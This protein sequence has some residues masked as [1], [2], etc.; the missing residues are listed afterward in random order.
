VRRLPPNDGRLTSFGTEVPRG[1]QAALLRFSIRF[2]GIIAALACIL[3]GFGL[4]DLQEAKFDVFPE[5]APPQTSIQ[6]EAPGLAPEQVEV[7][8]TQV[9]ENNLNGI[10]GVRALLS[11]S[12]PGLSVINVTFDPSSDIHLDRQIVAERLGAAASQLPSGVPAPV[13]EPLTSSTS[14]VLIVG[15]TSQ[16][17]S[18]M[19]LRTAAQWTIVP[20]L[21]AVPGVSKVAV[22]GGETKSIQIQVHPDQLKRFDLSLADVAAA[23]RRATGI[24]GAGVIDSPNQRI[25]LQASG[26]AVTAAEIA[27]TVLA[28]GAATNI[29]L[30]NVAD[31]IEAPEPPIG[32]AEIDGEPSVVLN[33]S[34]QYGANTL[35]V[36]RRLDAAFADLRPGLARDGIDLRDDLFRP[37]NFI[38]LA[39]GNVRNSLFLGGVLVVIV[40]FLFLFDL[41]TAAISSIAIPL[42]LLPAVT[43]LHRLDITLNTMTLGGLA[44]AIGVVVDDAVVDI[45]NIA[46]RLR[47]NSNLKS[48][49]PMASVVFDACFEVRNAVVYA[50][51]AVLLV[52]LP[53][54]FLP[55]IAGRLFAPLAV[56]YG[57]ATLA[58]LIVALTVTPAFAMLMLRARSNPH[59]P[60]L[61]QWARRH[62]EALLGNIA[63]RPRLALFAAVLAVVAGCAALPTF[64]ATFIPELK[65]GHYTVH[66]TALPGTSIAESLRL[67]T[68]VAKSL[69]EIPAIRSVTQRA[70][71][72]ELADETNGTHHSEIE[73]DLKPT[74]AEEAEKTLVEI[75]ERLAEIPGA[76]F[77]VNTFLT[78]RIEETLSGFTAPVVVN[79]LGNDL[80]VL[81]QKARQIARI[82]AKVRGAADV[83]VQSPPGMPV[84]NIR[85]RQDDLARWGLTSIEVLDA[86]SV[87]Y[88]G[89]K[90]G[91]IYDGSQ[92]FPVLV[93]LDEASRSDV[94][95]VGDL[96]LL[97]KNGV[98]LNLS[99]VA[100]IYP[101]SGRYTIAHENARR[102]QTVTANV[103]GRDVAS[104]VEEAKAQI[105]SEVSFPGGTYVEYRGT[106]EAQ[107]RS[108]NALILN[109]LV[110]GIGIALV[111]AMITRNARNLLLVLANIPFALVGG[112][113]AVFL[114][115]GTLSLGSM[116]G[117]VALF[118]ITLRNSI[119]MI[120]HYRDLVDVE[121]LPWK[122][123]TAVRGASD[124][125]APIMMTSLVTALGVLPL[126]LGMGEP[127]R[128]IEGPMAVVILGGLMTSMVLNLLLLPTLALRYGDF[129]PTAERDEFREP[130]MQLKTPPF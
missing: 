74:N 26:Q 9:L 112:V 31:V 96:P 84:L 29:T 103:T 18:L 17:R 27:R 6:T 66:M 46:R 52:A 104:F 58:S 79:V 85:L 130:I 53:V 87:A 40:L 69:L 113:I 43:I 117:F 68:I 30:G 4:Y 88:Q 94:S 38:E 10:P 110:A 54:L 111:L 36:T 24:R 118:G 77:S 121:G 119:L 127:G 62:Y 51:F 57:L 59:E 42:S 100:D 22:F 101:S 106:A 83:Q 81:D 82:L 89:E 1:P 116:V 120:A 73:V 44:I 47:E 72:A 28:S 45:E 64:G 124:R 86:V 37:A 35:E 122:L 105:D 49:R 25:V 95:S 60:P 71:R 78:E 33:V 14:V 55:G 125:L 50:T 80:D 99:E 128:E 19:D 97:T 12:A 65:E 23:A 114:S 67:G 3:I 34:E 41:R 115:G 16:R 93:I 20:K 13:L 102:L 63:I 8:I 21:L 92:V 5:F 70:G 76:N 107:T 90:V 75:R 98:H 61:I 123:Q 109:S 48:P 11:T 108:R 91:Q 15:L 39:T 129:R 56:S 2:R 32:A 126:A 7:L